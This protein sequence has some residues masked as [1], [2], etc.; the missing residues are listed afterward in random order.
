MAPQPSRTQQKGSIYCLFFSWSFLD[1]LL[2][3]SSNL[4]PLYKCERTVILF[5]E[6]SRKLKL[7]GVKQCAQGHLFDA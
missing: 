4:V 2:C 3:K 6:D 1:I 7:R 5:F